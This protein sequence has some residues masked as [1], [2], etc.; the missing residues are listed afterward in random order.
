MSIKYQRLIAHF[1][2][3]LEKRMNL[4]DDESV[5]PIFLKLLTKK[6]LLEI[7]EWRFKENIL[8][9]YDFENM[10]N[11][12]LLLLIGDNQTILV[13]TIYKW[14]QK[15]EA[16]V[17]FSQKEADEFFSYVQNGNHYLHSKDV[18]RWDN[19][20][21]SNYIALLSKAGVTKRVYALFSSAVAEE[22]KYIL[23]SPPTEFYDSQEEAETEITRLIKEENY[24]QGDLVVYS[25]WKIK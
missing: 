23:D 13:H 8:K 24:E 16:I 11:A 21:R 15:L 10:E 1:L 25:L 7:I 2:S 6:E 19:Y 12:E 20:D 5:N 3:M 22:H 18:T 9:Q 14:K 4:L 17:T